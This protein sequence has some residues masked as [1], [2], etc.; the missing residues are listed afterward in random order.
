MIFLVTSII[1][2]FQNKVFVHRSLA[3]FVF[4]TVGTGNNDTSINKHNQSISF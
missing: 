3:Y 4:A 2:I 1:Y